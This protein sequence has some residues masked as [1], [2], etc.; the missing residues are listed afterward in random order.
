MVNQSNACL[1]LTTLL[2]GAQA[3]CFDDI[4]SNWSCIM[5]YVL[6]IT[7]GK[8]SELNPSVGITGKISISIRP[9]K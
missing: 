6:S 2:L 9:T 1:E 7:S 5:R 8:F 4:R 3:S